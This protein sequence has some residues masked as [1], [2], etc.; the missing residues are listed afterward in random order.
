M[1]LRSAKSVALMVFQNYR[2][3]HDYLN[4]YRYRKYV[5][6]LPFADIITSSLYIELKFKNEEFYNKLIIQKFVIMMAKLSGLVISAVYKP[7]KCLEY[8][9][10]PLLIYYH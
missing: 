4:L 1:E 9:Q 10:L 3:F 7:L 5:C 2:L 6:R 8:Q